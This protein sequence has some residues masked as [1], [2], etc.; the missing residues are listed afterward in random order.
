[1][2]TKENIKDKSRLIYLEFKS[3][4]SYLSSD[5]DVKKNCCVHLDLMKKEFSN[6]INDDELELFEQAKE[7]I[8]G[9]ED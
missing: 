1:M 5:E 3:K 4:A 6:I 8:N 9:Y 7:I 2:I